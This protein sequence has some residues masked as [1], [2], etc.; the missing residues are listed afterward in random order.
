MRIAPWISLVLMTIYVAFLSWANA[1][2]T[3]HKPEMDFYS[4]AVVRVVLTGPQQ[5][6][7]EVYGKFYNLIE[8]DRKLVAAVREGDSAYRL[9]F[10]VNSPR[11]ATL[12]LDNDATEIFLL[13]DSSLTV[14]AALDSSG[15]LD[16][17]HMTFAGATANACQYYLARENQLSRSHLRSNRSATIPSEDLLRYGRV[18]DS[19]AAVEMAF[20][21]TF[22]GKLPMWFYRFEESE[23][24]YQKAYLKRSHAYNRNAPAGFEDLVADNDPNA[25]FSYYYYLYLGHLIH[26]SETDTLSPETHAKRVEIA[27]QGEMRDVYLTRLI[28]RLA[29]DG[30]RKQA[31]ALLDRYQNQFSS[32]RY[33]R[34]LTRHIQQAGA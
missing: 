7:H 3:A 21:K 18:L 22:Q 32:R 8:G 15:L 28:Y 20:L 34:F 1:R 4:K 30:Q 13:P 9:T 26:P 12:Y 24:R 31:Q 19:L 11:P 23:I 25:V 17:T 10:E 5:A 27:L 2:H 33:V 6:E 29:T 16:K 14:R